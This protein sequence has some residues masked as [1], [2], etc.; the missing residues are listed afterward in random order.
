MLRIVDN[1]FFYLET[2]YGNFDCLLEEAVAQNMLKG[3]IEW[4][5]KGAGVIYLPR[6]CD[7][8]LII[9]SSRNAYLAEESSWLRFAEFGSSKEVSEKLVA[10]INK[11]LKKWGKFSAC[12]GTKKSSIEEL[13]DL[14]SVISGF[15]EATNTVFDWDKFKAAE[16]RYIKYLESS[17]Q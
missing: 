12:S 5:R 7:P 9:L 13:E 8:L 4:Q 2:G 1:K 3:I 16:Q 6:V 14:L 10:D 17:L 11:D 15:K